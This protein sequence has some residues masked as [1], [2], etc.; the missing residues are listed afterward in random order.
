VI[1]LVVSHFISCLRQILAM[2]N[3]VGVLN[4]LDNTDYSSI[5][6]GQS[7]DEIQISSPVEDMLTKTFQIRTHDFENG[8]DIVC[9]WDSVIIPLINQKIKADERYE[10]HFH[11][12][13]KFEIIFLLRSRSEPRWFEVSKYS[14][15]IQNYGG[16]RL[17]VNISAQSGSTPDADEGFISILDS[18]RRGYHEYSLESIPRSKQNR[19]EKPESDPLECSTNVIN[20][21]TGDESFRS[22]EAPSSE[23]EALRSTAASWMEDPDAM[24]DEVE[25]L[26]EGVTKLEDEAW[27]DFQDASLIEMFLAS[28]IDHKYITLPAHMRAAIGKP[29]PGLL[30]RDYNSTDVSKL[31]ASTLPLDRTSYNL[32][33]SRMQCRKRLTYLCKQDPPFRTLL[34]SVISSKR[35]NC[36]SSFITRVN[37]V[38]DTACLASSWR[39]SHTSLEMRILTYLISAYSFTCTEDLRSGHL[40]ILRSFPKEAVIRAQ[41]DLFNSRYIQNKRGAD[42]FRG[43]ELTSYFTK[44]LE[45]GFS[46]TISSMIAR[47]RD[48][49][50]TSATSPSPFD[51]Y[52]LTNFSA[53]G[54]LEVNIQVLDIASEKIP[55]VSLLYIDNLLILI[56]T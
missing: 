54:S 17:P 19:I 37:T 36:D 12:V 35:S 5:I 51:A 28:Y 6:L 40:R 9:F 56:N 15:H 29:A 4:C 26:D 11:D 46:A 22:I 27:T 49:D 47:G 32:G 34:C 1:S 48:F 16:G 50:L 43:F 10:E 30:W 38:L 52:L 44:Y 25:A 55:Q 21:I 45:Y 2:L 41:R 8:G 20:T 7:I 33:S 13:L 53:S 24:V 23:I 18:A 39:G 42:G 31:I 3:C 14:K